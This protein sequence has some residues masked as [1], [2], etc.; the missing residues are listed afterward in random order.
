MTTTVN[1]PVEFIRLARQMLDAQKYG[2]HSQ[3]EFRRAENLR[4]LF[5][6]KLTSI[7]KVLSVVEK[8]V[9]QSAKLL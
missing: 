9:E 3:K 1:V 5:D 6:A 2:P 7:E 8:P 4:Q